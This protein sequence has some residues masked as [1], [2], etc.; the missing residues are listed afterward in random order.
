[1]VQIVFVVSL[2]L[3]V[4]ETTCASVYCGWRV[5]DR[6][7]G[8]TPIA[9]TLPDQVFGL[10]AML[11]GIFVFSW[12]PYSVGAIAHQWLLGH[13]I[14]SPTPAD[15]VGAGIVMTVSGGVIACGARVCAIVRWVP[16]I[17]RGWANVFDAETWQQF[18]GG[19]SLLTGVVG[20]CFA[21]VVVV[22]EAAPLFR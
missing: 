8:K 10:S 22:A 17:C 14:L 19:C 9:T 4:L 13:A 18:F 16:W 21:F 11:L 20:I 7:A 2:I 15:L 6:R 3:W 1:M 12:L 5:L